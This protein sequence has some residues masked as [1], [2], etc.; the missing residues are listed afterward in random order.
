MFPTAFSSL[1]PK[2]VRFVFMTLKSRFTST[3]PKPQP[4]AQHHK[5][6]CRPRLS[7]RFIS[8]EHGQ[9]VRYRIHP[10]FQGNLIF[11][12]TYTR[13]RRKV[14]TESSKVTECQTDHPPCFCFT[15]PLSCHCLLYTQVL[16]C[17]SHSSRSSNLSGTLL[18][19]KNRVY[20]Y[21]IVRP[22]L[23]SEI[24]AGIQNFR[25]VVA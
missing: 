8:W 12:I 13:I 3:D 4:S 5:L 21:C 20:A 25:L 9:S 11:R 19:S 15:P 16:P 23:D 2:H 10:E 6:V 17:L 18:E 14:V 7:F 22:E 24:L 1:L